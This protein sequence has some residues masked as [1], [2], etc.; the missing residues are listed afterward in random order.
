MR[1]VKEAEER[2]NE[3]LDVADELFAEK[4][5]EGTSTNDIL[6]RVGIAR[7]T[8]YYHF[9]SKE[10]IMDALIE[11]YS[12]SMLRASKAIAEDK[13]IPV[14]E[15]IVRAVMALNIS[16]RTGKEIVDHIHKPQNALMEQKMNKTIIGGVTPILAEIIK[17]GVQK[18]EFDTTFPYECT[19]MI[20]TY[21]HMIFD[22]ETVVMTEEDRMTKIQAFI[23]NIERLLGVKS[24]SLMYI[25]QLFGEGNG[26]SN[27][28]SSE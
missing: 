20:V 17:E 26:D 12:N 19:E 13:K 14:N 28:K 6:E 1:V 10:D 15:R 3:I 25:I 21:I 2:R 11:R 18:G 23:F 9:K 22:N 5:F 4:G 16:N 27:G 24:G 8:L 7:G